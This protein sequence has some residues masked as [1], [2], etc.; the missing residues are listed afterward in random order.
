M[1]DGL[2]I[3]QGFFIHSSSSFLHS[4]CFCRLT[5]GQPINLAAAGLWHVDQYGGAEPGHQSA[6]QDPGGRVRP[7]VPRGDAPDDVTVLREY[8]Q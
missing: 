1:E 7:G 8:R 2:A 5:P 6:D 3:I 4:F